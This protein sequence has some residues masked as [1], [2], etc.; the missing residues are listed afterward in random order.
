MNDTQSRQR[1]SR[2]ARRMALPVRDAAINAVDKAL[3]NATALLSETAEA[4]AREAGN[5]D[6]AAASIA[7]PLS[8]KLQESADFLDTRTG[9]A[10][11]DGAFGAAARHPYLVI[12]AA[13][14]TA[15]LAAAALLAGLQDGAD[16]R[17]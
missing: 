4:M 15:A 16:S 12:S 14:A 3:S 11:V 8:R 5:G 2:P 9:R 1:R 6:G 13:A 17:G 7:A 10:I